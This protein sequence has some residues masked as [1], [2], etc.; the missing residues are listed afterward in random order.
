MADQWHFSINGNQAGPIS[1]SELKQLASSGGLSR[2]DLVWKD[3]LPNWIAAE[4]LK[5]LFP[6]LENSFQPTLPP[7][8]PPLQPSPPPLISN[9]SSIAGIDNNFLASGLPR[10][11]PSEALAIAML[12]TPV[13]ASLILFLVN[14]TENMQVILAWGTVC[15]TGVLGFIDA[16][17]LGMGS[18]TDLK[19]T[20]KKHTGPIAIAIGIIGVWIIGFPLYFNSRKRLG[21][22]NLLLPSI[23]VTAVFLV[24]AAFFTPKNLPKVDAP[25]VT[26]VL[27][28]LLREQVM[29]I[30]PAFM[31]SVATYKP[32]EI[33]FD[34][35]KQQR[36][37][38]VEIKS[39]LG[40][41][42]IYYLIEW[43]N[44]SKD[45]FW[46]KIIPNPNGN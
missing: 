46:V 16:K 32:V 9:T 40:T 24:T 38:R 12:V 14:L 34:S 4:K 33:S 42:V 28:T 30:N 6:A 20:G 13:V 10:K 8:I 29:K 23:L 37:A 1:S 19:P 22:L 18:P 35:A 2:N 3:G 15:I 36:V 43:N 39:Q 17:S 26:K 25:E 31:D 44:R 27:R 21:S 45:L 7:R 41:E 5:G 11:K